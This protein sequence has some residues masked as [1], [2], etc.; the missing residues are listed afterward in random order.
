[1]KPNTSFLAIGCRH[2]LA[3]A[4]AGSVRGAA[5]RLNV[6][7]SAVS[8]QLALLE[9][10]TGHALFDRARRQLALTPAGET[11]LAGLRRAKLAQEEVIEQL[12]AL[13][14]LRRGLLRIA[15]VESLS[16]AFLPELLQA[17]ARRY[18]GITFR[19]D[20]DSSEAVNSLVREQVAD[21][22]F[23]FNPKS[24]EGLE[25]VMRR[26]LPLAAVMSPRHPLAKA[27]SLT[28]AQCLAHPVA[29]PSERL[30]MR[31][32]LDRA[33]A[34]K[35][36]RPAYECNSLRLMSS[37]ARRG[38]CIAFQTAFGIER[39]LKEKTLVMVPLSDRALPADR[40]M[41]VT[42][43]GIEARPA[44][45]ALLGLLQDGQSR[46]STVLK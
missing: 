6:A 42:R 38:Q 13:S 36:A 9:A 12:D 41:I 29:W 10:E 8:R 33:P 27:K 28:L 25:T 3:L 26:D 4:E 5:R 22:G 30:S 34:A 45:Q 43:R 11:L 46:F 24:L 19:I 17:F 7:P 14:G 44:L 40:M 31:A 37:L 20:V 35:E 15:S 1:M 32:I 23:T 39:E 21:I 16:V 18:P 2:F